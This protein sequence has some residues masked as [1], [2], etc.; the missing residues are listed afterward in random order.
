LWYKKLGFLNIV[1]QSPGGKQIILTYKVR[2]KMENAEKVLQAMR[3]AGKP[4]RPGQVSEA[5]TVFLR[6]P[7]ITHG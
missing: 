5:Q 3:E 4:V 7:G 2:L 1:Y 6:P